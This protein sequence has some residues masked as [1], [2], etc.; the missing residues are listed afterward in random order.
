[1]SDVPIC[2]LDISVLLYTPE[3][4]YDFPDKEVVLPVCIL[5]ELD[6]IKMDL[7]E[8]GRSS[9]IITRMLDEC[10]QLGSLSEGVRLPNGGKLRIELSEPDSGSLPYSPD[11]KH[12]SNKVLAVA[13]TLYQKSREVVFV[14]QDENLRTKA[15]ILNVPTICYQ[16][17][18]LDDSILYSGMH[19]CEVD[20]QKLRR[21]AKQASISKEEVFSEQ[22]QREEINPNEGLLLSS[23]EAP[24]EEVLATYNSEKEQFE[25]VSKEQG[26]WGIR[27]RNPEQQLALALLQNPEISVVTLSGKSGTGKTLLA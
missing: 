25:Q 11:F 6:C 18:R 22:Q 7:G 17:N 13:W 23:S 21:L 5:E 27:A 4:L 9:Q 1:M 14:S 8:K 10:R 19:H 2:V 24:D 15:D 20:K 12:I 3:A 16:G 26:V